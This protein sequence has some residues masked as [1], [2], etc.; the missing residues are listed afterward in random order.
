MPDDLLPFDGEAL[1]ILDAVARTTP[2][3]SPG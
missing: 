1:L 2:I 3:S